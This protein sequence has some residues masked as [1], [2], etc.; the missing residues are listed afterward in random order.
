MRSVRQRQRQP[1]R[2]RRI[3]SSRL[4]LAA[5]LALIAFIGFGL[6]REIN[7]RLTLNRERQALEAEIASLEGRNSEL[8]QLIERLQ[9]PEFAEEEA[10]LKLG[11]KKPGEKVVRIINRNPLSATAA[12]QTNSDGQT[13]QSASVP[14]R[15][16]NY[17]INRP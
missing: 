8:A 10:R 15:W 3:L 5:G 6:V 17:F 13:A 7:Q 2:W 12:G 1:L 14:E 16:W 11:L 9:R 4:T